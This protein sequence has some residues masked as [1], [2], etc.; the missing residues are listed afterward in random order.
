MKVLAVAV[1]VMS[2]NVWSD[3]PVAIVVVG[4]PIVIAD[5]MSRYFTF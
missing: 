2:A 4:V 1:D 5:E 3:A